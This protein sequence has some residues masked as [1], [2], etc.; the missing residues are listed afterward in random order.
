MILDFKLY[1]VTVL[2][3]GIFLHKIS[4]EFKF[5]RY[6]EDQLIPAVYVVSVRFA[7]KSH[8]LRVLFLGEQSF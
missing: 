5:P 2:S 1:I 3:C 4:V 8:T 6:S 7:Q